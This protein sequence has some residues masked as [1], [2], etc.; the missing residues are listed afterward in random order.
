[1]QN[2]SV[3]EQA[4]RLLDDLPD[5]T[6]WED[7][8]Y[9]IYVRQ[10]IERPYRIIFRIKTDQIDILAITHSAQLLPRRDAI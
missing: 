1:M 7:L 2:P 3:K 9:R 8:I 10:S 4:R 6:M 5:S